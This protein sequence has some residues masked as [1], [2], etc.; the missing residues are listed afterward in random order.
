MSIA[1]LAASTGLPV[2]SFLRLRSAS[3]RWIDSVARVK[4]NPAFTD[5]AKKHTQRDYQRRAGPLVRVAS[6]CVGIPGL[7]AGLAGMLI[8]TVVAGSY[9]AYRAEIADRQRRARPGAA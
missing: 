2:P 4:S 1:I 8:L 3:E 5:L 6:G 7:A 9:D